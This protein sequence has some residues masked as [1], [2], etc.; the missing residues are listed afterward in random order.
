M[1]RRTIHNIAISG[2]IFIALLFLCSALMGQQAPVT[3]AGTLTVADPQAAVDI[4]VTGFNDIAAVS[5]LL[6]Y[7]PQIAT[8][9]AVT[10]HIDLMAGSFAWNISVPGEVIISW[11]SL[12]SGVTLP[13]NSEAFTLIFTRKAFG[14][15]ALE[16][17]DNGTSCEFAAWNGGQMNVLPDHPTATFYHDGMLTFVQHAPITT[18]SQVVVCDGSMVEVP[19]TVEEFINIGAISL[20]F[21]FDPAVLAFTGFV[22][23]PA[24]PL[25]FLVGEH[26]PGMVIAS[27]Y[28]DPQDPGLTLT[29]GETLFVV[30]FQHLGGITLLEWHDNGTSCEYALADPPGYI[31]L[32]DSPQHDFYLD[33]SVDIDLRPTV[34]VTGTATIDIGQSTDITFTLTGTPP[35][36]LTWSDG[37]TN[38]LVP[39]IGTS[40]YVLTVSPLVT[41]TYTAVALSDKHCEALTG[42]ITGEAVVTVR[43]APGTYLPHIDDACEGHL[44]EVP[45]TVSDFNNIGVISLTMLYDENVLDF[46]GFTSHP[47]LPDNFVAA[48][49]TPGTMVASGYIGNSDPGITLPDHTVL[50]TMQFLYLGGSTNLAWFD[51]GTSCEYAEANTPHFTPLPDAPQHEYYFDGAI[52]GHP[53]PT[54]H[55]SGSVDICPGEQATV[56]FDLTG[57]PPWTL[58]YSENGTNTTTVS[59]ITTSPYQITRSFTEPILFEVVALEDEY[60]AA[61]PANITGSALVN[62]IGQNCA[63]YLKT[64]LQGAYST[65]TKLMRTDLNTQNYLPLQQPYGSTRL[66]YQGQESVTAFLPEVVD[67]VVLELRTGIAASTLVERKAALVLNNGDVVSAEDQQQPPSFSAIVAG[68]QYYVVIYHRNHLPV[69]TASA[70]TLPNSANTPHDFTT[71]P[72]TNTYGDNMAVRELEPGVYGQVAGDINM[73]NRLIYTGANNDRALVYNDIQTG[74]YPNQAFFNSLVSGYYNGDLNMNGEVRYSGSGNDPTIIYNNIQYFSDPTFF[75]LIHWSPTPVDYTITY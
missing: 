67:W 20:A 28:V 55:V 48:A 6:H 58:T 43:F 62:A 17:Y 74:M 66:A 38:T 3:V 1:I 11:Y 61:P 4:R 14:T 15:T 54:A 7:D 69:M 50:F 56:T 37:V 26:S 30:L 9:V 23:H 45:V 16:W 68:A 21:S 75:N 52:D 63:L 44:I 39:D 53:S 60:C 29:D 72:L 31:P 73:D 33:G 18:L 71:S 70:I 40:P 46:Q 5:L 64:I 41:T 57:T 34:A 2:I 22:L 27:G 10:P 13:V 32:H 8:P 35:W 59:G 36:E 24:L 12:T 47:D 51:N 49:A 25:N 65:A 19:V 42:D